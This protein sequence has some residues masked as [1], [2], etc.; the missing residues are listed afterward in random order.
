MRARTLHLLLF[1]LTLW[2]AWRWA[3]HDMWLLH[4]LAVHP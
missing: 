4:Y 2:T 1:L 3:D